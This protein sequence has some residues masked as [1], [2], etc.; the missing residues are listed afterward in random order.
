MK[1]NE[2]QQKTM[3]SLDDKKPT[4]NRAKV[5]IEATGPTLGHLDIHTPK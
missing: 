2:N 4:W 3:K 1:T 5:S